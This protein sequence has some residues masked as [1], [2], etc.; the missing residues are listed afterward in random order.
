MKL[1]NADKAVIEESK[2]KD[3]LLALD[4]RRGSGKAKLLYSLGYDV[5]N[6]QQ[7]RDDLIRQH[8][9][10]DVVEQRTTAWGQRYDVVAHLSQNPK[11]K[12]PLVDYYG[13]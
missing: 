8:L 1:P 12:Y 3:Y 9:I 10:A 2:V 7:L 11:P 5:G 6:W 4:H 13:R